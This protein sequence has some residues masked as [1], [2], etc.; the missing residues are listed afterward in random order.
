M[1]MLGIAYRIIQN[2]FFGSEFTEARY[3][4]NII[5]AQHTYSLGTMH[6]DSSQI[7]T[8][9]LINVFF[10]L[11]LFRLLGGTTEP[12]ETLGQEE[13]SGAYAAETG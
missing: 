12:E 9:L 2:I 10:T 7:F 4:G 1:F 11:A 3:V 5:L 6:G 8:A 13:W